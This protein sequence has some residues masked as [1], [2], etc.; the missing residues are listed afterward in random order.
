VLLESLVSDLARGAGQGGLPALLGL[1]LGLRRHALARRL[2]SSLARLAL[3]LA[4]H[5]TGLISR[6]APCLLGGRL[7][8]GLTRADGGTEATP[9][10]CRALQALAE[11]AGGAGRRL[12][13]LESRHL[14]RHRQ[15]AEEGFRRHARTPKILDLLAATPV[16]SAGLVGRHLACSPQAGAAMLRKLASLGLVTEATTRAR[17]KIYLACDL[18]SSSTAR[19]PDAASTPLAP[20]RPAPA[21]D[22][23]AIEQT[24]DRLFKDLAGVERRLAA[25]DAS[26]E[27]TIRPATP[28]RR[29]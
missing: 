12:A 2:P 8:L 3:P 13:A 24:L 5:A 6:P 26:A 27:P 18:A 14:A 28:V 29:C 16:L 23:T 11:E 1:L 10:L 15:L 19:S 9:W 25:T 7:P 17:W 4:L 20:S 22:R 21:I